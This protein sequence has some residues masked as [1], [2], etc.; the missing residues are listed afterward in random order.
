MFAA[1]SDRLI[2]VIRRSAI[3]PAEDNDDQ[4]SAWRLAGRALMYT[5]RFAAAPPSTATGIRRMLLNATPLP[6]AQQAY[7]PSA[8]K[9]QVTIDAVRRGEIT[10]EPGSFWA[11]KAAEQDAPRPRRKARRSQQGRTK[12]ARFLALTADRYGPLSA[13][14]L[15]RVA[16]IAGELAPEVGLHQGSA[17]TALRAA[18]LAARDGG[19][20]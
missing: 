14:P 15:E 4:R 8:A 3:G 20:A 19:E 12:T 16:A 5:L 13:L 2:A 9:T 10:A 17:R 6:A 7:S 11:A 1:G 18:A